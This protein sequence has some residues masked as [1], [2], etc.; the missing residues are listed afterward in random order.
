MA[1]IRTRP[2]KDGSTA[3]QVLWREDGQP[4]HE[5][6]DDEDGAATLKK[7]LDANHNRYA[8]A[9]KAALASKASG[10]TVAESVEA[11]LATLSGVTSRTPADYETIARLHI[12][13]QLGDRRTA[14][15]T[16]RDIVAWVNAQQKEG[17]APKSIANRHGLLYS[18]FAT[19]VKDK[20][21]DDNPCT[22]V[23][24][25]RKSR[26]RTDRQLIEVEEWK[27][28]LAQIPEDRRPVF[29]VL[30]GTGMR[31][32]E[33]TA[34]RVGSL[35]RGVLYVEEAWKRDG[36]RKFYM[37]EPKSEAGVREIPIDTALAGE[38]EAG[39]R[40]RGAD[41]LLLLHPDGHRLVHQTEYERVWV[42]AV[43][44]AVAA[45]DVRF[46]HP[47]KDL[48]HSHGS[49]LAAAGVDL[50]TIRDRLGHE[51][52]KTTAD[53]YGHVSSKV[54]R[55]AADTVGRLLG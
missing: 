29:K 46:Y 13:P 45:G 39:A 7:F 42:P 23:R 24:L 47:I 20:V 36:D 52:I 30:A 48:R 6:F 44:R 43:K 49:W 3:Y 2:R 51:S 27:A 10:P 28:I 21:R 34:L 11:H 4:Q 38:L 37:G 22:D 25:P 54:H 26:R 53:V 31:W 40:G 32:G 50:E 19:A 16:H 14:L 8:L 12:I 5:T 17:A 35:H 55:A 18:V 41:E 1:S 33:A 15:V 9:E